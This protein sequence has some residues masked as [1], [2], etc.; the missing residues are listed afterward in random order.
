MVRPLWKLLLEE[1]SALSCEECFAVLEYYAEL[2]A[3]EQT[4]LLP[5]IMDRM[6]KCPLCQAQHGEALRLLMETGGG[7]DSAN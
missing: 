2:L 5:E 7:I 6:K 3:K 1:P 4:E